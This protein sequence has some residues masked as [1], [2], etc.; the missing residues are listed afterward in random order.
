MYKKSLFLFVFLNFFKV[1]SQPLDTAN[2]SIYYS[3]SHA[4]DT[5]FLNK[6]TT[7][8]FVLHIGKK[9]SV[10]KTMDQAAADSARNAVM[11]KARINFER[12][13][14]MNVNMFGVKTATPTLIY[15]NAVTNTFIFVDPFMSVNYLIESPKMPVI[16]WTITEETK[17]VQT[18]TCQKATAK[19]RGRDYEAWFCSAIPYNNGP[20]KFGGL[21]GLIVEVYDTKK[22]I[23]FSLNRIEDNKNEIVLISYPEKYQ[24][25]TAKEYTQLREEVKANPCAFLNGQMSQFNG[26]GKI[27]ITKSTTSGRNT[28][29]NPIELSKD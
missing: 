12:T 17:Q 23:I 14:Q 28:Y 10:Y 5:M 13:G 15:K 29:N 16:N 22:Q 21:P 25:T 4:R 9:M 18:L 8:N 26:E 24:K 6:F 3:L 11:E 19:F 20:W 2:I 7:E 1:F 27:T